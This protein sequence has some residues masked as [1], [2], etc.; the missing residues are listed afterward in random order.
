MSELNDVVII[1]AGP[2][3]LAAAIYAG[4]ARLD[5]LVLER[6]T[7]GGQILL[8][9]FIE[10]YP[11]F[12]EGI[13]PFQL[14]E[15]IRK[16]AERFGAKIVM[17]DVQEVHKKEKNWRIRGNRDE[18]KTRTVLVATG[19]DHRKL[20]IQGEEQLTGRGVSYCATCDGAFF[21]NKVVAVVGG[22]D[23]AVTEALFLTRFCREVRIIHRR[24]QLRAEKILQ[25]RAFDNTKIE[26]IWDTVVDR[27][28]GEPRLDSV[29]IR[30]VKDNKASE[31]ELDG[32]FISIGTIPNNKI[33][34]KLVELNEW[35]EVMVGKKMAT[36]Q[37]GLYAAGDVTDACPEQMATAVG[38]GVAAAL[39]ITEY[40]NYS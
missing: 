2:A 36:K 20:G 29:T 14:M 22:G 16:Q 12:T 26:V 13:A 3:G 37:P 6:A 5:T 1:G 34:A 23:W 8:T 33:V 7:P 32:L 35:G 18:Y 38:T 28:N 25:E 39:A 9:D 15:N 19:S 40:L 17:D 30:N 10:N 11:G 21:Q 27:I 24:D 31:L 4:R